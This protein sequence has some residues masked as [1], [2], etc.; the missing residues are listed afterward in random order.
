LTTKEPRILEIQSRIE[1]EF[2][3]P[4]KFGKVWIYWLV[5]PI[6][7]TDNMVEPSEELIAW[8]NPNKRRYGFNHLL[9]P[10]R[11]PV[12]FLDGLV[13]S[14]EFTR[15]TDGKKEIDRLMKIFRN[16]A[17]AFGMDM[18]D[19]IIPGLSVS[20]YTILFLSFAGD[21]LKKIGYGGEVRVVFGI[22]KPKGTRLAFV[23]YPLFGHPRY[24]GDSLKIARE[25]TLTNAESLSR[26][27]LDQFFNGF[28]L[29]RCKFFDS[30]G[31]WTGRWT[32]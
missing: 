32:E 9:M 15:V 6:D 18:R 2:Q 28:G 20:E 11:T 16:G 10:P 8:L 14:D 27:L 1:E 5:I 22:N 19:D 21:L 26:S 24:E 7:S 25:L 17:I 3:D 31:K 12:P 13:A 4:D 30:N 29:V 23:S